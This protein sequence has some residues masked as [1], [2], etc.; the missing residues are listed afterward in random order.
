MTG[1]KFFSLI[2]VA[3]LL[4]LVA[5]FLTTPRNKEIELIGVVDGNEVI[6]S[7]QI[8][9]R[10]VNLTVDE[11]SEVKKGQLVAE[12]D[13][14]ELTA[15]LA[16]AKANVATLDNSVHEAEHSY[17]WTNDQ[18]GAS[19]DQAGAA[20]SATRAQ[21]EQAKAM[22]WRDKGD[23]ERMQKLFDKGEVSA[24]DRDHADAAFRASQANVKSLED[25]VQAQE[26]ALAVAQANRKQVAMRKSAVQSSIAQL[27]QARATEAQ[28]A[29]QLGYT[30][31]YAPIDGIVSVRVAKQGEM[32]QQGSPIVVVVD[33]DH[34]WVRADVPESLIDSIQFGQKVRVRLPSGDI[35]E[36]EVYFKGVESDF[37]TQRDVSRMKRDIRTFA[38]K[39]SVPN[40]GRRLFT[41]MTA[42]VLLPQPASKSWFARS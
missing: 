26:G 42:T 33:V 38:I 30:E 35:L 15:S 37:A 32:V 6:V 19:I 2:G 40:P 39:V 17:S 23:I 8:T 11:G 3:F 29:T 13:R 20:L 18:T 34:L 16:A 27:E 24:Q 31:V 22:L 36:G 5:Y 41:G 21:L 12:L 14:R 10:M 28:I 1:K 25:S 7:P 4:A 9:G